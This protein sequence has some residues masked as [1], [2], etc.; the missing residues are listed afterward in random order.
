MDAETTSSGAS[1]GGLWNADCKNHRRGAKCAK[2]NYIYPNLC[3][4][5][6]FAVRK[7]FELVC[8]KIVILEFVWHF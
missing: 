2:K 1:H 4:L 5:C 8:L 7:K 6:V 3:V